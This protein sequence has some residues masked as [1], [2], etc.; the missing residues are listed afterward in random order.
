MLEQAAQAGKQRPN[1][2]GLEDRRCD[3]Q[4]GGGGRRERRIFLDE[5]FDVLPF[6]VVARRRSIRVRER[7]TRRGK[8]WEILSHDIRSIHA[9]N[10]RFGDCLE[11]TLP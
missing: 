2:F 7:V 4:R 3:Q 11:R 9:L 1:F 6:D 8:I 10:R 5:T